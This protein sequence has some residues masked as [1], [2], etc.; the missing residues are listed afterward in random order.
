MYQNDAI[1]CAWKLFLEFNVVCCA[2]V[3][4][5][6]IK[7]G[8]GVHECDCECVH[9]C[10]CACVY[11]CTCVRVHTH[12]A[13]NWKLEGACEV[14]VNNRG[15][16]IGRGLLCIQCCA[17]CFTYSMRR[18]LLAGSRQPVCVFA[19]VIL[20]KFLLMCNKAQ[21]YSQ[22]HVRNNTRK[23]GRAHV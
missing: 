6:V 12:V 17:P 21:S 1:Y 13:A 9:V 8:A 11:V 3:L 10:T 18:D 15:P 2:W 5:K 16:G 23:I 19:D 4:F 22:T 14:G 7:H 20:G